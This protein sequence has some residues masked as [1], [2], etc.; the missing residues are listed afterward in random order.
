MVASWKAAGITPI[1]ANGNA[2]PACATTGNPGGYTSVISVGAIGSY[3]NDPTQLAYFSSKGT[4]RYKTRQQDHHGHQ[5]RH[6]GTWFL[7]PLGRRQELDWLHANGWYVHGSPHVAGVVALLKSAQSDLTYEEIYAYMTKTTD[8]DVLK[9]EPEN[10]LFKNGTIRAPGAPNCGGTSDK[11]WP[12]NRYGYGRVNV[13]TILRDGKLNDTPVNKPTPAATPAVTTEAPKPTPAPTPAVTGEPT[14]TPCPP[15]TPKPTRALPLPPLPTSGPTPAPTGEPTTT[16]CPPLTP[17]PTG[18]PTT[19]P[20]PP[21]T[22]KPTAGPTPA[23]TSAPVTT[24]PTPVPTSTPVTTTTT[25]TTPKPTTTK[26]SKC[27]KVVDGID[28]FGHDITSTKRANYND[29]CEDCD[30]TPGCVVYVWTPW[31]DGTCFLKYKADKTR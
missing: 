31:E 4:L 21:L 17:K 24:K 26:P 12:N 10:W 28:Y 5:A 13:G 14:T 2:G 1:F 30:K 6:L 29:C 8:R 15:L 11:A 22:P 9:A 19:T 23:P 16:P 7:H 20:C 18:E 3:E 25:T 27:G